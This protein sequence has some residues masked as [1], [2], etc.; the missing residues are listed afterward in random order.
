M[1]FMVT[2]AVILAVVA[3]PAT[4]AETYYFSDP[5]SIN[6]LERWNWV[7]SGVVA[8]RPDD[9]PSGNPL[10]NRAWNGNYYYYATAG[11]YGDKPMWGS[12][13][14]RG[15][16]GALHGGMPGP[17]TYYDEVAEMWKTGTQV[18]GS[19]LVLPNGGAW[20][21]FTLGETR[22]VGKLTITWRDIAHTP[23]QWW[24]LDQTG[25]P[26]AQGTKADLY[27][28]GVIGGTLKDNWKN[29]E[30]LFPS[31]IHVSTLTFAAPRTDQTLCDLPGFGAYLANVPDVRL[32]MDGTF[33]IFREE[34]PLGLDENGQPKPMKMTVDASPG[35]LGSAGNLYD[36]KESPNFNGGEGPGWVEWTF[37][38]EYTFTGALITMQSDSIGGDLTNY[39][40]EL[41]FE[42][43][44]VT[45]YPATNVYSTRYVEFR[46]ALGNLVTGDTLKMSWTKGGGGGRE[47]MELQLFGM[48]PIPEPATMT[49]L[50]LG[51][52][53]MLRRGRR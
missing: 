27:V 52:L 42:V 18:P 33:N 45:V 14:I 36:G 23:D 7:S 5:T 28:G 31:G 19:N 49:L 3:A 47:M 21:T 11:N 38:R 17:G 12:Q 50:A 22:L 32:A 35:F 6:L 16:E 8:D 40:Q 53:A 25:A 9:N 43:D 29:V 51:G 13:E 30:Y 24:I 2:L 1:R 4:L 37:S 41:T 26:V 46:D 44:G 39:M 10:Y 20:G 48:A 15:A 34:A